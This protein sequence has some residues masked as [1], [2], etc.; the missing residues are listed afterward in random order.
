VLLW[1]EDLAASSAGL[2]AP[3]ENDAR[4]HFDLSKTDIPDLTTGVGKGTAGVIGKANRPPPSR[5][6]YLS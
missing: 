5:C 1:R 6:D 3:A 2:P 4:V